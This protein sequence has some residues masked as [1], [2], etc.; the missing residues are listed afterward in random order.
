[1][2][3][4]YVSHYLKRNPQTGEGDK[5]SPENGAPS[6]ALPPAGRLG[7]D[8]RV[9]EPEQEQNNC[10][11]KQDPRQNDYWLEVNCRVP[12]CFVTARQWRQAKPG[13][14]SDDVRHQESGQRIGEK[15][16]WCRPRIRSRCVAE[17]GV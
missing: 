15:P 9:K 8:S 6:M 11:C 13:G 10:R 1:M 16:R 17:A 4:P 2:R 3:V 5:P 7:A 12:G 14:R